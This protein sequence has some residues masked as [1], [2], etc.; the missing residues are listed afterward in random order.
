MISRPRHKIKL[1]AS[2][3]AL[4]LLCRLLILVLWIAVIAGQAY[5]PEQIPIH[6]NSLGEAD[7]YGK[8]ETLLI[9]PGIATLLYFGM[10][11]LNAYPYLF[12]YPEQVTP[13]NALELYTRATR[14]VRVLKLAVLAIFTGIVIMTYQAVFASDDSIGG[15][16]V[17]LCIVLLFGPIIVY[18]VK[19]VVANRRHKGHA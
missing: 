4:E 5:L 12:N 10:S 7:G 6:F 15:W 1:R 3:K 18:T 19:S 11:R 2:D 14:L 9:L 16:F 8:K 17:P 13:A